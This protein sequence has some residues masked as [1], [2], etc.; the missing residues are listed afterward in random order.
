MFRKDFIL[1]SFRTTSSCRYRHDCVSHHSEHVYLIY[2]EDRTH[3]VVAQDFTLVARVL[4]IVGLDVLP[5][6]L[7]DL[8]S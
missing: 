2:L 4:Q 7:Y 5:Y 6:L 1:L 3:G 8:G